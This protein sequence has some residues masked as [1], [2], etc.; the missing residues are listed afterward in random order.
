MVD[1]IIDIR[2]LDQSRLRLHVARE[3]LTTVAKGI[4]V[5]FHDY[6]VQRGVE[7]LSRDPKH[8]SKRSSTADSWKRY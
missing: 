5:P 4:W 6:A 1:E 8:R 3:N 2:R 7:F